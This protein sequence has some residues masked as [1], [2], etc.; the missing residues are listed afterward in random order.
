MQHAV[1]EVVL[2][3]STHVASHKRDGRPA[4][5]TH[6]ANHDGEGKHSH[7]VVDELKDDLEEVGGI[8]QTAD[9]DEGLHRKVVATDISERGG[10]GERRTRSE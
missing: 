1:C 5:T 6:L 2:D 4:P 8:R 10:G 9:G 3:S 7:K